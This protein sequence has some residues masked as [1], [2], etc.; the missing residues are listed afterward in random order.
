[1][2]GRVKI[3]CLPAIPALSPDSKSGKWSYP[4]SKSTC[5]VRPDN[6]YVR[7]G[8]TMITSDMARQW[9]RQ[10]AFD[11]NDYVRHGPTMITSDMARQWLRQTAFDWVEGCL[12][13]K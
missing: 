6:D 8:P 1:V 13:A 7:Y 10:T 4:L 2:S 9:L 3:P 12:L 11:D 5:Q